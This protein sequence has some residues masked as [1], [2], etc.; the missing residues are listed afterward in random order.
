MW[1]YDRCRPRPPLVLCQDMVLWYSPSETRRRRGHATQAISS[2]TKCRGTASPPG[3]APKGA[4]LEPGLEP[5]SSVMD[6]P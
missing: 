5:G 6:G 4:P 3:H 2:P 1:C